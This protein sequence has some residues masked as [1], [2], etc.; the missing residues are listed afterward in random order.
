M[1]DYIRT[2]GGDGYF[3][4]GSITLNSGTILK[5]KATPRTAPEGFWLGNWSN[6]YGIYHPVQS[7]IQYQLK[8]YSTAGIEG[9]FYEGQ[10][11]SD[12]LDH[13]FEIETSTSYVKVNG[14]TVS[15]NAPI[16]Q[17]FTS[18]HIGNSTNAGQFDARKPVDWEYFQ[19]YQDGVLTLDLVPAYKNNQYC[20][21]DRVSGDYL[22]GTGTI[23]GEVTSISIDIES[24]TA[25]YS[26]T[27]TT[28]TVTADSTLTWTASTTDSWISLVNP[29][30]AGNGSFTVVAAE[31]RSYS[32]RTG[33]VSLISNGG[34]EIILPVGQEKKPLIV[35][36]RPI[37]RSGDLVKKMYRSGELIYL[38][39][40]PVIPT[41]PGPAYNEMPLTFEILGDGNIV[42]GAGEW[43]GFPEGTIFYSKNGGEWTEI[44]PTVFGSNIPVVTGD[45]V[46][47]KGD[48]PFY[49]NYNSLEDYYYCFFGPSTASFKIYG[50]IM[51]LCY[52]TGFENV[53]SFR[54]DS[55]DVF[56]HLFEGAT[57]LTDAENLVMPVLN[58]TMNCYARMFYGCTNLVTAPV[59]P[60]PNL[61]LLGEYTQMFSN[62]ASLAYVKC[63]A[64]YEGDGSTA[65]WL[66]G[67]SPTGTFVK[68]PN[69]TWP[70]GVSGIPSGW[71]VLDAE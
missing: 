68:D 26:G 1:A 67:V 13:S 43:E 63:L 47:F 57:G 36:D 16:N 28:V 59:L 17:T 53:T 50:N 3:E 38:R 20:F 15:R 31:N 5:F 52:S 19:I 55:T 64:Y 41:P 9:V 39:M 66:N 29:T 56:E 46:Q 8:W 44:T 65:G 14:T 54:N 6:W 42:W 4:L 62:C 27:S 48:N 24:I 23:G 34:D 70:T 12:I 21:K 69:A 30:G 10:S 11:L 33:S 32:E 37:Y 40:E 35:Y 2:N 71:T 7:N 18:F 61:G 25:E 45:I 51:S 49:C 58:L 22:Y 60:A